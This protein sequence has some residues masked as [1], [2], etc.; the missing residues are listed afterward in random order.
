MLHRFKGKSPMAF[1]GGTIEFP[2]RVGETEN[3]GLLLEGKP[4]EVS[5]LGR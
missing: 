3:V 2:A 4:R 1:S 5:L